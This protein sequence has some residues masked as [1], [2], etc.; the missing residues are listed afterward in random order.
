MNSLKEVY[1]TM[2]QHD[3]EKVAQVRAS[4][5]LAP[6]VDLSQVDPALLKQAQHY[7]QIGRMLGRQ[8]YIDQVKIA[9][10][11]AGVPADKQEDELARILAGGEKKD[12]KSDEDKKKDEDKKGDAAPGEGE[13]EKK[14]AAKRKMIAK[15]KILAK[16]A[17]DPAYVSR[18]IS[19]HIR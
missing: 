17:Q 6:Q 9:L 19:K 8:A 15:K 4:Q 10:D 18:L 12:E 11:E 13:G 1:G 2:L 5:G 7:D 14:E 16:M 3:H